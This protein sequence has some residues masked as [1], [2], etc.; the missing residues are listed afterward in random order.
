MHGGPSPVGSFLL[1]VGANAM[2]FIYAHSSEMF[3]E[4][5]CDVTIKIPVIN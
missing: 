3:Y 2:A 1:T 5:V 4:Q